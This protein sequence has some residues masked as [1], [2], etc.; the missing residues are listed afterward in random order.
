[1]GLPSGTSDL[2]QGPS[3]ELPQ[4]V[5]QAS[6]SMP[7]SWRCCSV[8]SPSK[9]PS[10]ASDLRLLEL[11]VRH[12]WM[13]TLE[14][15]FTRSKSARKTCSFFVNMRWQHLRFLPLPLGSDAWT[16]SSN[17]SGKSPIFA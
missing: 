8:G 1:M 14:Q 10:D 3:S 4:R 15:V 9:P 2:N 17:L 13:L 7:L 11:C 16:K 6:R 5:S 12:T